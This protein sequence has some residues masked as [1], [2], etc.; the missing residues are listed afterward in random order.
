MW[1]KSGQ[2]YL[3]PQPTPNRV[4]TSQNII[5]TSVRELIFCYC[6]GLLI[7]FGD[8]YFGFESFETLFLGDVLG[9]GGF[10][11]SGCWA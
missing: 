10:C 7:Y 9:C 11:N 1:A 5:Q 6:E 8:V 3:M 2:S 4:N